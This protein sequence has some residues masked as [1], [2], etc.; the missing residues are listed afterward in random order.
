VVLS[1]GL[2]NFYCQ[3]SYELVALIPGLMCRLFLRLGSDSVLRIPAC[4]GGNRIQIL[5]D[6]SW[7]SEALLEAEA[8]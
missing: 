6:E 4:V 8:L 3:V 7:L 2:L 1:Y 5:K